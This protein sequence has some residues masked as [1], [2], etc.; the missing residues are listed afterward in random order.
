MSKECKLYCFAQSGNSYKVALMLAC[1]GADWEPVFVDYLSGETRRAE[2]RSNVNEMGE[3]PVLEHEGKTL[4]QSGLIL[5]YLAD[6]LGKFDAQGEDE[7]HEVLRWI[8]FDNHKFTGYLA[9]YRWMRSFASPQ[10]HP[11][12][13]T[14]LKKRAEA[15]L[16]VVENHLLD[17]EF[18]VGKSATI[19]DLSIAGYVFYPAEETGFDFPATYPNIA[20][21]MER[22]SKLPGWK[23]PYDLLPGER[24]SPRGI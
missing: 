13:L 11:E 7:Q 17:R 5:H 12:V 19:A 14:F 15:A 22:V 23:P 6:H 10:P 8:L 20:R 18:I 24:L 1:S 9:T 4:S 3:V 16:S 21:W 2:W